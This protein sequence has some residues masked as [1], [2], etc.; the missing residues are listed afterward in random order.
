MDRSTKYAIAACI[1]LLAGAAVEGARLLFDAPWRGVAEW[2]SD[3]ISVVLVALFVGAAGALLLRRRSAR[4]A[5]VAWML[6]LVAPIAM[7]VH[8]C[9]TRV[10]GN[11]IGMLYFA[12]AVLAGFCIKRTLD[13]GELAR[14][15]ELGGHRA[16]ASL[17]HA[18]R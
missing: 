10:L 3:A 5:D 16:V 18:S 12:G 6:A 17:S 14:L 2:N 1:P 7:G 9:V 15:R 13:R 8:A 11:P 4:Y